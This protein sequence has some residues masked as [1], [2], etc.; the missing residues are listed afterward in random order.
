MDDFIARLR[1]CFS[2]TSV[3]E[4]VKASV[5]LDNAPLGG[6]R[7]STAY[8]LKIQGVPK[9]RRRNAKRLKCE[10]AVRLEVNLEYF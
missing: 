1:R 2:W 4:L 10:T 3:G 7:S 6:A 5:R 8:N 9:L